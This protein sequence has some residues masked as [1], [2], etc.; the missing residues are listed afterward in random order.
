MPPCLCSACHLVIL[1]VYFA[2]YRTFVPSILTRGPG[3]LRQNTWPDLRREYI[4]SLLILGRHFVC[5]PLSS[6]IV[7]IRGPRDGALTG[8]GGRRVCGGRTEV[9][10]GRC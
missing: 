10:F 1:R 8:G 5:P 7:M 2:R 9:G 4:F 6:H 3:H